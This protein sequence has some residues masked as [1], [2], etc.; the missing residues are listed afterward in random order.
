MERALRAPFWAVADTTPTDRVVTGPEPRR[1]APVFMTDAV[2]PWGNETLLLS[3]LRQQAM[4]DDDG[5]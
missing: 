1:G 4:P 2:T 3:I 5:A